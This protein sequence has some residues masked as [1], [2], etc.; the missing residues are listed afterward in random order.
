MTGL[1][2]LSNGFVKLAGRVDY[3]DNEKDNDKTPKI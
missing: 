3:I 2:S 1:L